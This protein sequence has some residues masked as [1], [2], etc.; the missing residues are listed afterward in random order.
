MARVK[1]LAVAFLAAVLAAPETEGASLAKGFARSAMSKLLKRDLVRDAASVAKPLAKPRHVWRYTSR[2]QA[3]TDARQGLAP[4]RHMTARVTRGRSPSSQAA[5][6]RYGL[7]LGP[8]VRE[9]WHLPAGM[10]ARFAKVLRG[11]PGMGEITSTMR[12]PPEDLIKMTR[13]KPLTK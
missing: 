7:P 11:A 8:E 5:R 9:T 4:G 13:L 1:S 3:A 2:R 12:L 6:R 10:P